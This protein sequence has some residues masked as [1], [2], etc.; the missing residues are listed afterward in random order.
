DAVSVFAGLRPLVQSRGGRPSAQL[1]RD[2]LVAVSPGG[3][4]TVTGGKWTTYRQMAEDAVDRAATVGELPR[5][6]CVTADR[7]VTRP[8]DIAARSSVL[9]SRLPLHPGLSLHEDGIRRAISEEMAR[10]IEDVLARRTRSLFLDAAASLAV[11]P[12]V[13]RLLATELGW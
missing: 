7:R 5:R 13:A 12:R 11:A 8:D 2:H 1:S 10:T 3:L 4:V 9:V 6:P